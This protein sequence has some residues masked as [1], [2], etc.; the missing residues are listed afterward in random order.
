MIEPVYTI[1]TKDQTANLD[2]YLTTFSIGILFL[3]NF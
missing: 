1:N 3:T 2:I